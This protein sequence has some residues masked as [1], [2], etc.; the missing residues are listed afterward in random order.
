MSNIAADFAELGESVAGKKAVKIFDP[1]GSH[2]LDKQREQEKK[3]AVSLEAFR[4]SQEP[5]EKVT[6]IAEDAAA[7]KKRRAA[8]LSGSGKQSTILSGVQKALKA[9]LGE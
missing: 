1:G 9:R 6:T 8:A 5:P 2:F 3:D 4:K 7:Q